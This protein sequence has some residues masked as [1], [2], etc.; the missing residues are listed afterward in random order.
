MNI[1][2]VCAPVHGYD[3][4]DSFVCFAPD[5]E[6]AKRMSPRTGEILNFDDAYA[7]GNHWSNPNPFNEWCRDLDQIQVTYLGSNSEQSERGII[8]SSFN[9]G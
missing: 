8:L 2:H 5:S 7:Y 4:F 6:T 3:T 9:A 1:Y